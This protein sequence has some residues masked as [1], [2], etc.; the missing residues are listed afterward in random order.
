MIP[1]KIVSGDLHSTGLSLSL[2]IYIYTYIMHSYFLVP[3]SHINVHKQNHEPPVIVI[4]NVMNFF[5]S[6][7]CDEVDLLNGSN[8]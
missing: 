7:G 8:V 5:S 4:Q 3:Q 6:V 2:Y 1:P